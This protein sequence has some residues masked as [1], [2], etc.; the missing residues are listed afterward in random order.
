MK[1]QMHTVGFRVAS[2]TSW[3]IW[4]TVCFPVLSWLFI[5]QTVGKRQGSRLINQA[6][7]INLFIHYANADAVLLSWKSLTQHRLWQF[8]WMWLHHHVCQGGTWVTAHGIAS[9]F[10]TAMHP[11]D[12]YIFTATIYCVTD[13]LKNREYYGYIFILLFISHNLWV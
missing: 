9:W 13:T 3:T 12:R 5:G 4:V 8:S 10:L 1:V 7:L 6:R 11:G 2:L